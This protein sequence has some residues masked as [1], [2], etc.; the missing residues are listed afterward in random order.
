MITEKKQDNGF[1]VIGIVLLAFSNVFALSGYAVSI[2]YTELATLLTIVIF[3]FGIAAKS[4]KKGNISLMDIILF[5]V[6]LFY[7]VA[8]IFSWKSFNQLTN[9]VTLFGISFWVNIF[10]KLQWDHN[11][12]IYCGLACAVY[13][14]VMIFLFLPGGLFSGWN[15]NSVIS[16]FPAAIFSIACFMK[17]ENKWKNIAI[18]LIFLLTTLLLL[19][20]ENRSAFLALALFLIVCIFKKIY[21][22]KT[23]FRIFYLI[24]IAINVLLPLFFE[25]ATETNFF[26]TLSNF[27]LNIFDKSGLN[28]REDLWKVAIIK[29]REHPWFGNLGYRTTYFHNF[30][31]D[32]L[33]QFGWVGW[34]IFFGVLIYI[35]EKSFKEGETRNLF[36]IGFLCLLFLNTFESVLFCNNYFMPFSYLLIG[37]CWNKNTT[38]EKML[39]EK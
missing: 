22:N 32:V 6:L 34:I 29:M 16:I 38:K 30:S 36:L 5:V 37:M 1:F 23:R 14:V 19:Q 8:I 35:L 11:K 28:G 33:I 20:L 31:L 9:L 21:T 4:M 3:M 39:A 27:L 26:K 2:F 24:V 13:S 7:T 10:A 18:T 25:V 17:V 12:Y 15:P